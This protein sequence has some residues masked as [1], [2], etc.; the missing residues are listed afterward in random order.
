MKKGVSSDQ[1]EFDWR[2]FV[3]FPT[4]KLDSDAF[5]RVRIILMMVSSPKRFDFST[6]APE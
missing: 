3:R 4:S 6:P 1:Q 2:D 5:T